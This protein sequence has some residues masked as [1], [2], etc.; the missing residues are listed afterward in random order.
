MAAELAA[1]DGRAAIRRRRRVW[2]LEE[3]RRIVAESVAPGASVSLVARRHDLNTNMLF[4]WRRQ[5]G[6]GA[7]PAQPVSFVPAEI[8][9]EGPAEP[10]RGCGSGRIEIVLASGTRVIVGMDVSESAL[11]CVLKVLSRQR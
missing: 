4:T 6:T 3:K 9:P 2:P 1:S 10:C 11:G 5:L 7:A 8:T